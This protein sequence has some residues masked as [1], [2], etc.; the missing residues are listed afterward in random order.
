M[1]RKIYKNPNTM[2]VDIDV[3]NK[4]IIFLK[5]KDYIKLI[6]NNDYKV[7]M[8]I[9]NINST[10]DIVKECNLEKFAIVK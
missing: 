4:A 3:N 2:T 5:N 1:K 6:S 8:L 10:D 7:F 9:D